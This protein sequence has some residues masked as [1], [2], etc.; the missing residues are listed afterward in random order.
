M[1]LGK[2]GPVFGQ[3]PSEPGRV[4]TA[5]PPSIALDHAALSVNQWTE[6]VARSYA[7]LT[8]ESHSREELDRWSDIEPKGREAAL[9]AG[10]LEWCQ[11]PAF[12]R[13]QSQHWVK[14]HFGSASDSAEV[15]PK[16]SSPWSLSLHDLWLERSIARHDSF[17]GF[18]EQQLAGDLDAD[19]GGANRSSLVATASWLRA[20]N[21]GAWSTVQETTRAQHQFRQGEF[22]NL[23]RV[24]L[25]R[26]N[27]TPIR[28]ASDFP[29]VLEAWLS[30]EL[31]GVV[32]LSSAQQRSQIQDGIRAIESIA[33]TESRDWG[34]LIH[35][36]T[37]SAWYRTLS[38]FPQPPN[39]Q[40]TSQWP[41]T[42]FDIAQ[43]DSILLRDAYWQDS[44]GKAAPK[45]P[46]TTQSGEVFTIGLKDAL[47]FDQEWT[48]VFSVECD[49]T[50]GLRQP[51]R[52]FS[53][54]DRTPQHADPASLSGLTV[55]VDGDRLRCRWVASGSLQMLEIA[56]ADPIDW[57]EPHQIAIVYNGMR[58]ATA[59][60]LAVDGVFV[61]HFVLADSMLR[62]P[63]QLV[64]GVWQLGDKAPDAPPCRWDDFASYR[65]AL[66]EP[67]L[68]SL[69]VGSARVPWDEMD[70]R[71]QL[72]WIEHFARRVDPHWRYERES[73][74]FYLGNLARLRSSLPAI[75]VLDGRATWDPSAKGVRRDRFP[76]TLV[77]ESLRSEA[78]IPWSDRARLAAYMT[79]SPEGKLA[80]ASNEVRRQWTALLDALPMSESHERVDLQGLWERAT[81]AFVDS[82]GD[83]TV[84][85]QQLLSSREWL[86]IALDSPQ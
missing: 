79:Q 74:L 12:A 51:R 23:P 34:R 44:H 83:R 30:A 66:S 62:D 2:S 85:L 17:Y 46:W 3:P 40:L 16:G 49:A 24:D 26:A 28:G 68:A 6:L 81:Q 61:D 72:G 63:P 65:V 1:T 15:S 35:S 56:S 78:S 70:A 86:A 58:S 75:A 55:E 42:G 33:Q 9:R 76:F 29:A 25:Q 50:R 43:D 57:R 64:T 19:S 69:E 36:E 37:I 18:I 22:G 59:M 60:R 32:E 14:A 13:E 67:E 77:S 4:T 8:R 71:Q 73:H 38:S 31:P 27:A 47:R 48:V 45:M 80:I 20:D 52:L 5:T 41:S 53:Q 21:V 7:A 84:L 10:I 82:Q 39:S 11:K 54:F